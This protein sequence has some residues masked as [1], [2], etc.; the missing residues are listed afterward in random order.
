L[1]RQH[2]GGV[3]PCHVR[4][5][6]DGGHVLIAN[7]SDGS[8]S[9]L[10]TAEDGSLKPTSVR[11]QHGN[12]AAAPGTKV[13]TNA[14]SLI[15]DPAE[16]FALAAD[17]G[18]DQILVYRFDRATSQLTPHQPTFFATAPKSGP[19]HLAFHPNGRT[20]YAMTEYDNTVIAM[21][22]D[23]D[24][25]VL[26][27]LQIEPTLPADFTGKSYGADIHVHPTGRFLYVTNRGHDS[28]TIFA[29]DADS[30]RLTLV[31]REPVGGEFP[32][33]FAIDPTGRFLL[34]GNEKSDRIVTFR[35]DVE[36]GRLSATGAVTTLPKPTCLQ[37]L[38]VR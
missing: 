8:I 3:T 17:L 9:M 37:F 10:P 29:V 4:V 35:I 6:R 25:G 18:L 34:V 2:A 21:T 13:K 32:R 5:T 33:G 7:Y 15:L 11:I 31:G 23:G 27:A 28:I 20:L 1:N 24:A 22:Y 14:H 16:R 12:P 26:S 30:G 36:T 38:P 19:R